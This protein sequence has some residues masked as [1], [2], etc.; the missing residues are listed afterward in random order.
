[1]TLENYIKSVLSGVKL[2]VQSTFA[3]KK[4]FNELRDRLY[5]TERLPKVFIQEQSIPLMDTDSPFGMSRIENCTSAPAI[6]SVA[7]V[8]WDS[9]TYECTVSD[10]NGISCVG[11]MSILNEFIGTAYKD[12]GEPFFIGFMIGEGV[13]FYYT[14]TVSESHTVSVSG[15]VEKV[16]QID[17]KYIPLATETEAGAVHPWINDEYGQD[18]WMNPE[19]GKL[20]TYNNFYTLP[21]ATSTRLGGVKPVAKTTAMTQTVGVDSSGKL[22]TA[23]A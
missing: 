3:K 15:L 21:V 10:F 9:E 14:D 2:W 22:Y 11:N 12:T 1:M 8:V 17:N 4:D 18:V 13:M 23:P 6:D 7:T 19:T 16:H 20:F 5:Y